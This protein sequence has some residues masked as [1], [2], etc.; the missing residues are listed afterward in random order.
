MS[1]ATDDAE[2]SSARDEIWDTQEK[3]ETGKRLIGESYSVGV[4]DRRPR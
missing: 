2:M 4:L 1:Y 3:R